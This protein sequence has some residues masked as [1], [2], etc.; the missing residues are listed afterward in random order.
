M[1]ILLSLILILSISL[2]A[3]IINGIAITVSNEAITMQELSDTA[4]NEKI[5][6][7]KAQELLVRKK[8][9]KIEAH[10]RNIH[11]SREEVFADISK[12]AEQNKLTVLELYQAVQKSNNLS[13]K[14]FKK[15]IAEKLLNQKLYQAIAYSSMSEPSEVEMKE[16][17]D[18][19]QEKFSKPEFVEAIMYSAA[20]Q[21]RL[22]E[23]INNPMFYSPDV[24]S[25]EQKFELSKVNPQLAELLVNTDENSFTQV[26]PS[27]NGGFMSFYIKS[28]AKVTTQPFEEAKKMIANMIMGDKRE[29]VLKDYFERAKLNADV[30]VLRLPSI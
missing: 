22:M 6:I 5:T 2:Y 18:L 7:E 15:R 28:K 25:Q 24:K 3:K 21:S 12:M 9:E 11:I 30:K 4:K 13:E 20:D 27:P 29:S 10:E 17:Y 8:L 16:Y 1:K 26:F 19:H 14:E 23:K